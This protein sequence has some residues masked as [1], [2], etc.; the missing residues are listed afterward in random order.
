VAVELEAELTPRPWISGDGLMP[1]EVVAI[2]PLE[3][4]L[5]TEVMGSVTSLV[6]AS[7]TVG[8]TLRVTLWS[9]PRAANRMLRIWRGT[10][11]EVVQLNGRYR[12]HLPARITP[13]EATVEHSGVQAE[14]H[15]IRCLK[16]TGDDI[17]RPPRAAAF[18]VDWLT[19]PPGIKAFRS[20]A[21]RREDDEWRILPALLDSPSAVQVTA[22]E[23]VVAPDAHQVLA[24]AWAEPW[25]PRHWRVVDAVAADDDDVLAHHV[26]WADHLRELQGDGAIT[27][28]ELRALQGSLRRAGVG[29]TSVERAVQIAPMTRRLSSRGRRLAAWLRGVT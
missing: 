16:Y 19:H 2:T 21:L 24:L 4:R 8:A 5:T 9:A 22:S 6:A 23:H 3:L 7:E 10:P 14:W 11:N 13:G 29:R 25:E 15:R 1:L 27:G 12:W 17:G 26:A 20:L 18:H 28:D